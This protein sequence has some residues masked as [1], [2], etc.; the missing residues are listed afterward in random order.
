MKSGLLNFNKSFSVIY[1]FFFG[2]KNNS[3]PGHQTSLQTTYAKAF[4]HWLYCVTF[5]SSRRSWFFPPG[6]KI[7]TLYAG[8]EGFT[9]KCDWSVLFET[10][11]TS[12][13]FITVKAA[14]STSGRPSSIVHHACW[15]GG[16]LQAPAMADGQRWGSIS[17]QPVTAHPKPPLDRLD[18]G[19]HAE[20]DAWSRLRSITSRKF[21]QNFEKRLNLGVKV[22]GIFIVPC[23]SWF[24]KTFLH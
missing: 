15:V 17:F 22:I 2:N 8:G 24:R 9:L 13:F 20:Y 14:A 10:G 18:A 23:F 5:D 12:A 3:F 19:D 4:V 21:S 16:R 1:L 6:T 11:S 7:R